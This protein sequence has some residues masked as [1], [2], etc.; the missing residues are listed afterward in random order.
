[1]R[2]RRDH[3]R[4][5]PPALHRP[6]EE[7]FLDRAADQQWTIAEL[8]TAYARRILARAGGNKKRA[9]A[10]LGIDRRTLR[11]WLGETDND[12]IEEPSG[13]DAFSDEGS[14]K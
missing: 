1:M 3:A 9:A 7:D 2:G 10:Y 14:L 5:L 11:R 8:E 13:A 6:R 12:G 4:D